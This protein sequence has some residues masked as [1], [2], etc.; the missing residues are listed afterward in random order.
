MIFS[1][2][3]QSYEFIPVENCKM[4]GGQ[5][6]L[7]FSTVIFKIDWN[8][9]NEKGYEKRLKQNDAFAINKDAVKDRATTIDNN[10]EWQKVFLFSFW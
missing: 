1:I 4:S 5:C 9:K 2:F 3:S 6:H 10:G 7:W 8:C